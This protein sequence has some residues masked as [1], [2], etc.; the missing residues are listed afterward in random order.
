M[1]FPALLAITIQ[2]TA[3]IL[4]IARDERFIDMKA[5][6]EEKEKERLECDCSALLAMLTAEGVEI[7]CRRCHRV[8][9][10]PQDKIRQAAN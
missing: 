3:S 9:L 7:K 4:L 1:N 5:Q 2:I 8:V 10:I 6:A